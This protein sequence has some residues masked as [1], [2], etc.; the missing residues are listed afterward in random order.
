MSAV[1]LDHFAGTGWGVACRWLGLR[2]YGVEIMREAI[3]TR[4]RVGFR[5]VYRD[6]W[7]GLLHPDLVPAHDLYIASPPCQTFS[8]AGRGD[9]RRALDQVLRLIDTGAWKD[10]ATLKA[11]GVE[12]GDDRTALVLTPLAHIWAHRP[13]LIALEQVPTVLPV[14][15]AMAEV[16]R[17]LGY[18]VWTGNLQAEQYGVPQTRKRAI[19]MARLDG[20]VAPPVPTHSRYYS[21][22][23]KRLDLGVQKWVS[24]A[25]ALGWGMTARPHPTITTGTEAGGT[26]PAALGGSGARKNVYTERTA[27]RWEPSGDADNDGGILRL[28]ASDAA[29]IQTYPWGFVDRPAMTVHGHG[30]LTRG[31]SGQKQAIA[32][33]LESGAFVPR[34]P[35]TID[36]ARK[37][38][39]QRDDYVS[40][41]DRYEPDAVNFTVQEAA[42][43]Q[44]YPAIEMRP[45]I[46]QWRWLDSPATTVAG[47]PRITAREHHFHGEQ[48]STSLKLRTDEAARFQSFP[49]PF[50]FQ[51]GR[52]KQFL[53]IGNAVPPLLAKAIISAL[54]TEPEVSHNQDESEWDQVF[55]GVPA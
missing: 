52:G 44:S 6:V 49:A 54:I 19:L 50:P 22:E 12:L 11:A 36:T 7:A 31:P 28:Q 25:E 2:E 8:V 15:E 26:D 38:G 32:D 35:F 21:R 39:V 29:T 4:S 45:E 55:S 1:V 23:P 17:G 9:G 20:P 33:G 51:G 47:D 42:I 16:L 30:L 37:C 24:M 14:W 40:L 34:P 13:K 10:P 5:T 41:S 18:S 43:L 27:G 48:N 3:R 46:E 53:Q